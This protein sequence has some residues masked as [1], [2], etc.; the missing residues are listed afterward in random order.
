[1]NNNIFLPGI[2]SL[3]ALAAGSIVIF[4]LAALQ[5]APPAE[6]AFIG[7]YFGLGVPLFF[8]LSG[9]SLAHS[10]SH[11]IGAELWIE[12]YF[13]KRFYRIAPLFYAVLIFTLVFFYFRGVAIKPEEVFLNLSFLYNLV[14]GKHESLVY[15]GWT[16][17]VEMLFYLAF[18]LIL[19]MTRR[20]TVLLVF[21]SIIICVSIVS[22]VLLEQ[23]PGLPAG[24]SNLAVVSNLHYFCIGILS[25][26]VF[27]LL[28]LRQFPKFYII[29]AGI[30]G[31]SACIVL[32]S[33]MPLQAYTVIWGTIFGILC[34][35][36]A[37]VPITF[38]GILPFIGERSYSIYLVQALVL[39]FL[40]SALKAVK[41]VFEATIHEWAFIPCAVVLLCAVGAVALIT[42]SMIEMPGMALGRWHIKKM[43]KASTTP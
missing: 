25:F 36:Q 40:E 14:P 4:H 13:F 41:A 3:R 34:V 32:L 15:A 24:Y 35:W 12:V 8:V 6:L 29:A 28:L 9:F 38:F 18:P 33:F 43:R 17:G 16:I 1:M 7:N 2:H 26:R 19:I 11:K 37:L 30:A 10:T 27:Q 20:F 31:V 21:I 5:I 39:I 22:R 42:Y 23:V